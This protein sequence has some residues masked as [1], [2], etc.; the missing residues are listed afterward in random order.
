MST[1]TSP[2]VFEEKRTRILV[3]NNAQ[4]ILDELTQLINSGDK[5]ERRWLWEL[6][7]NAKDS[8]SSEQ[9][10]QIDIVLADNTL[11]FQHSGNPFKDEEI[12]H[13]IYHGS[14]KKDL[15]DKSGKFGTGFLAT[16]LLSREV[17]ISGFMDTTQPFSFRLDRRGSSVE[18]IRDAMERSWSSFMTSLGKAAQR[19]PASEY[20]TRFSYTL[21]E[22][23]QQVAGKG[24][25]DLIHL[26]PFVLAFN[27]KLESVC[28]HANDIDTEYRKSADEISENDARIV[29][30]T[31]STEN[32]ERSTKLVVVSHSTTSIAVAIHTTESALLTIG[33]LGDHVP[34]LFCDFP[35]FGTENYPLPIVINS[36]CFAPKPDRD[37]IYLTDAT[38][39]DVTSNK[40]L[41][42]ESFALY[43]RLVQHASGSGWL[44]LPALVSVG[45][46]DKA[47]NVDEQWYSHQLMRFLDSLKEISLVDTVGE[48]RIPLPAAYVPFGPNVEELKQQQQLAAMIWPLKVP[49]LSELNAWGEVI[50][51]WAL[52]RSTKPENEPGVQVLDGFVRLVASTH[53]NIDDLAKRLAETNSETSAIEWLDR[54]LHLLDTS[55]HSGLLDQYALI[56]DQS[57]LL[58]KRSG[59]LYLDDGIDE[60]LKRIGTVLFGV[61]TKL[62]DKRITSFRNINLLRLGQE[63]FLERL[64]NKIKP[65]SMYNPELQVASPQLFKWLTQRKHFKHLEGF[66][67]LV[68]KSDEKGASEVSYLHLSSSN[69]LL[70]PVDTWPEKFRPFFD[71]FPPEKILTAVYAQ[72]ID[73]TRW[74]EL[75]QHQIVFDNPLYSE[76][77]TLS[78]NELSVLASERLDDEQ[79]HDAIEMIMV[80][81]L[82]FLE[83]P[84][85]GVIDRVRNSKSRTHLFLEFLLGPLAETDRGWQE[86]IEISCTCGSK[87]HIV[88]T[89]WLYAIKERAWVH[90]RKGKQEQPTSASLMAIFE[91]DIGLQSKLQELTPIQFLNKL[92]V[93]IGDLTRNLVA[94]DEK[95]RVDWDRAVSVVLLSKLTPEQ[96]IGILKDPSILQAYE[97]R[98]HARETTRRNQEVGAAVEAAF[99]AIFQSEEFQQLGFGIERTGVG[100]DFAVDYDLDFDVVEDNAEQLFN[101]QNQK[102]QCLVEIKATVTNSASMTETQGY[103]AAKNADHFALCVVPLSGLPITPEY[104]RSS[105]RFV[106]NIGNLLDKRVSDVKE[107]STYT[108]VAAVEVDGIAVDIATSQIRFKIKRSVWD[109]GVNLEQFM[110]YLRQIN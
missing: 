109:S 106:T 24:L 41:M 75:R 31:V 48:T 35:L 16:H 49:R 59:D 88:S 104:V 32:E 45:M 11:T 5:F 51:I 20:T 29:S 25:N 23:G 89:E 46:P 73:L 80:S 10:V 6:L 78:N 99:K 95:T 69:L 28:V 52:A 66:P 70:A 83:L 87:H 39:S 103:N 7:Q 14:T 57:G 60:E 72:Q 37:G 62:L 98:Q 17:V 42:D 67:V 107:L 9:Q 34:R 63:D 64:L 38:S 44:N 76:L 19:L 4:T 33:P 77:A 82:A 79:N 96:T 47:L 101:I 94:K 61:P 18:E 22:H 21:D 84:D 100:S 74:E 56:P 8:V 93:G 90:V 68:C 26:L 1:A 71:L 86:P 110:Q 91:D 2:Q 105:A 30:I 50:Q 13:L 102:T 12:I 54:F 92:G 85:R 55:A 53:R 40:E 108:T 58:Q 15:D 27:P 43:I 65:L 3:E 81:R 97:D 36:P